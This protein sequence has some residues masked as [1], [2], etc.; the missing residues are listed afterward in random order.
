VAAIRAQPFISLPKGYLFRGFKHGHG[1]ERK[2][3]V[4]SPGRIL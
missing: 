3:I 1:N 2:K 4:N